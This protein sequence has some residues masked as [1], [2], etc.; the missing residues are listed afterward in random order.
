MTK[1]GDSMNNHRKSKEIKRV[2]D[3]YTQGAFEADSAKLADVFHRNAIMSG[4]LEDN[5]LIATP[6]AFIEDLMT[7]PS[8]KSINAPYNAEIESLRIEGNIAAV[9]ISQT[10]FKGTQTIVNYFHLLNT[11]GQ[12]KIISKIFTTV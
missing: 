11:D 10:G 1:K 6:K 8:M 7:G 12:W 2:I 4:F 9:V 5:L 3:R